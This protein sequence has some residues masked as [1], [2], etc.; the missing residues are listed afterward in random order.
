MS[1]KIVVLLTFLLVLV[2]C[3]TKREL[4]FNSGTG[5]FLSGKYSEKKE[6][7]GRNVESY[8]PKI[9]EEYLPYFL[10][11]VDEYG[12]FIDPKNIS[13]QVKTITVKWDEEKI[14]NYLQDKESKQIIN[15]LTE[16]IKSN[17]T[18]SDLKYEFSW[19]ERD[20]K[21]YLVMNAILINQ[22]LVSVLS[23]K[24]MRATGR[25][26]LLKIYKN[27]E[28]H[29][30]QVKKCSYNKYPIVTRVSLADEEN[31]IVYEAVGNQVSINVFD[32]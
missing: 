6:V 30:A 10:G 17:N 26:E 13:T 28:G 23:D 29:T 25:E 16:Y 20:R 31:T 3:S 21:Q 9:K 32:V 15:D 12:E 7:E 4:K 19:E 11:W 14:V 18:N 24:K 1:K 27:L 2:G 22:H 5:E 8:L